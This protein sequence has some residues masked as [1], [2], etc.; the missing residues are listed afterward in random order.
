MPLFKINNLNY[1][2]NDRIFFK[3]LNL[4]IEEGEYVSIIAPN[5][6]GKSMLTK[7]ICAIYPTT[8]YCILNNI[9]LN[10]ENV[11]KYIIN[12]G[13]VTNDIKNPFLL[14]KVKDELKYS[15]ENL[16]YN[17]YKIS[18]IISKTSKFFEIEDLLNKNIDDLTKSEKS[19]LL[20]ILALIHDPKLL[21]LDDAFND[22]DKNTKLFMLK[23]LEYLNES[24]L[25]ILNITS[26]LDTIYNSDKVY[27]MDKFKI[28]DEASLDEILKKDSYLTKIGLEIPYIVDLSLKLMSYEIIDKIYF[29]IDELEN[30]LWN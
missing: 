21:V 16:G 5:K 6:S 9:L 12:L 19:K 10:K 24:G 1:E 13:I 3:D 23:K 20:I 17:D 28:I 4:E 25:T 27:V 11:L 15:L 18:K 30:T 26:K 14:K 2:K 29:S 8:D 7:I 22:M